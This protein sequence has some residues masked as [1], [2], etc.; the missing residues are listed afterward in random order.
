MTAG[1]ALLVLGLAGCRFT[2]AAPEST[3]GTAAGSTTSYSAPVIRPGHDAAAVA[4]KDLSWQAGN[5]LSVGVPVAWNDQLG[6]APATGAAPEWVK[7]I[8]NQGGLSRYQNANGCVLDYWQTLNQQPLMV[9]EDDRAST[10]A[11]FTYL[12]PELA[13]DAL[14][15]TDWPW[16]KDAG[17]TS[18]VIQFLAARKGAAAGTP[19]SYF[20]ARMLNYAGVGLVLSLS[21]PSEALID[22]T[23]ASARAGLTVQPPQQ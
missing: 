6:R 13:A 18:P 4:A 15:E 10:V 14:K 23:L 17:K 8:S 2:V 19:A 11:L 20:S 22:P 3:S 1:C 7:Q 12:A 5:T 9:T 21:C 16:H